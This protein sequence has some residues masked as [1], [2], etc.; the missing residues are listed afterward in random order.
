MTVWKL[1][2]TIIYINS[3]DAFKST[4]ST[5]QTN[6]NEMHLIEHGRYIIPLVGHEYMK[7]RN[8]NNFII[9]GNDA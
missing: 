2:T 8:E 3:V 5:Q 6:A 7:A 9:T 4:A 1:E